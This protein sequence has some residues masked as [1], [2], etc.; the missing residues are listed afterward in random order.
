MKK[1]FLFV[2][3][4]TVFL[5]MIFACSQKDPTDEQ[6]TYTYID[7]TVS[8]KNGIKELLGEVI[9][10]IA[11]DEYFVE[12]YSEN[13]E[14]GVNFYTFDNT[15]DEFKAYLTLYKEYDNKESA[16]DEYGDTWYFFV[17]GD[18]FVDL[19]YHDEDERYIVDVYAYHLV[20]KDNSG[21]S[22]DDTTHK[23]TGFS[24]SEKNDIKELL[25]E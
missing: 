2:A 17:K 22:T 4:F 8:E 5:S 13:E 11:N 1:R 7:F 10:F 20:H 9:P 12:M 19:R 18:L 6:K 16:I 24:P 25:G 3:I 21:G 23:Y 15:E 14:I